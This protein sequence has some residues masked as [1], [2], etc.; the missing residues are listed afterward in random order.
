[1]IKYYCDICG[2]EITDENKRP[3]KFIGE[4][5]SKP[6]I[7]KRKLAVFLGE[8]NPLGD[9]DACVCKYCMIDAINTTDDR[10]KEG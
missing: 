2:E 4:I 7:P 1:M 5:T 8:Q 3:D 9:E 6:G 10:A